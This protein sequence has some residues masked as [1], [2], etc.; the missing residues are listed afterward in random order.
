MST[1]ITIKNDEVT[2][3][4][5][6]ASLLADPAREMPRVIDTITNAIAQSFRFAPHARTRSEVKRRFDLAAEIWIELR[7]EAEMTTEQ[8]ATAVPPALTKRLLGLPW[9]PEGACKRRDRKTRYAGSPEPA[10]IN[11]FGA[12]SV[13]ERLVTHELAIE[14]LTATTT[15]SA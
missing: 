14:G 1:I 8:L 13:D 9:E 7:A 2:T 3:R 12:P 5:V 15:P 6:I 10:L 11:A 4:K